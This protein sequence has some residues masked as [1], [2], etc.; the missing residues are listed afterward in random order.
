MSRAFKKSK[1][2]QVQKPE[3]IICVITPPNK[4]YLMKWQC[5]GRTRT[6][7]T[8]GQ[9]RELWGRAGGA[10]ASLPRITTGSGMAIAVE[11]M[12]DSS[13]RSGGTTETVFSGVMYEAQ[14]TR[15]SRVTRVVL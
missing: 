4:Q 10:R 3:R 6:K 15:T 8:N 14:P 5:G 7:G 13:N 2:R 12:S 1:H 11:T 9:T